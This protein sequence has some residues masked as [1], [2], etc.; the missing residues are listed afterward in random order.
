MMNN[1]CFRTKILVHPED[2]KLRVVLNPDILVTS[3][4]R[5]GQLQAARPSFCVKYRVKAPTE[6]I[7]TFK[8]YIS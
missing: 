4:L 3:E 7:T 1:I 2:S 5:W 8:A 6:P